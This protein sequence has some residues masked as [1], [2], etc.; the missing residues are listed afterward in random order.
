MSAK[1]NLQLRLDGVGDIQMPIDNLVI[2]GLTGRDT[3]AI[4]AHV[5]EL[6]E[7]GV[8]RPS[9][10]PIFYR[11]SA[12]LLSTATEIQMLGAESSGEVEFMLFGH[13]DGM[14]V[15]TASDHTD[16]EV[17]GYSIPVSKQMCTKPVAA[18]VWRFDEVE[19]HF[20]DLILR[21]WAVVG[22]ERR[23]Y[24]EGAVSGMRPPRE[25]IALYCDGKE[26]LPVG[27]AMYGGTFAA[28]GGVKPA[29]RFEFE[30]EDPVLKR[31]IKH[32]YDIDVLPVVI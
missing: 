17:E 5:A 20:D 8:E 31:S 3:A 18:D 21:S 29:D 24:Q 11:V 12:E 7:I 2:A 16:R 14:M 27:T 25:L 28:I 30:L 9:S 15:G 26:T 23:L 19:D 1:V 4:E 32:A 10:I 13:A 6:A 22:G